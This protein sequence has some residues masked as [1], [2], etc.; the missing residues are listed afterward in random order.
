M[1][2]PKLSFTPDLSGGRKDYDPWA[3]TPTG[4]YYLSCPHKQ[5]RNYYVHLPESL[6][7][8][9]E[10]HLKSTPDFKDV[11]GRSLRDQIDI[12]FETDHRP[13]TL[14]VKNP[15][16]VLEKKED[17]HMPLVI[18][19]LNEIKVNYRLIDDPSDYWCLNDFRKTK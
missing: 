5:G 15:I 6:K 17:T 1:E 10:Y 18:T 3:E 14:F 19:N 2:G 12:Q 4:R 16:S 11:F 13:P 7:A 8:A 9:Q